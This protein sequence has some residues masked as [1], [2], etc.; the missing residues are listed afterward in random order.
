MVHRSRVRLGVTLS[1]CSRFN[2]GRVVAT[3]NVLESIS[4]HELMLGVSR[5]ARCDWGNV[6]PED[7]QA[8][9]DSLVGGG[10][11]FSAYISAAGE[12]FWVITEAD[13]SATTILLP[14]DY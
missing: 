4:I 13:R 9:D 10:R 1:I 6:P 12:R 3:R 7:Q 8:N 2:L 14:E 11:L 5:H